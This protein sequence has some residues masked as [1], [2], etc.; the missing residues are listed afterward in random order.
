MT[1]V[2]PL[3]RA[4]AVALAT[5][6]AL[7]AARA[8]RAQPADWPSRPIRLVMPFSAGSG[9]DVITR[10]IARALAERLGTTIVVENKV[11]GTGLVG[12]QEV[13]RAAPDGYTIAYTNIALP[14][15]QELLAKGAFNVAR[16]LTPIGGT[17][18]SINVLVVPPQL[19]ARNVAELVAL[20]KAR[21]GA[22]SYA[23]GGN[24]TP[25]HLAGEVFKRAQGLDVVHVPYKALAAAINDLARGDVHLLFG[26]SGSVV[27]A[28]QGRRLRALAVAGPRRLTALPDVPTMAEAGFPGIDVQSWAG[29][30]AP[31]ATPAPIVARIGQALREVLAEPETA[32]FL[33]TNGSEPFPIG[34]PEFGQLLA[35]ESDRWARFVRE[36]GLTA[37]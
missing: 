13:A 17:S 6:C 37:D 23:S 21:P 4:F 27:P 9:P 20:L 22:Y 7:P 2:D 36:T 26:T 31:R 5:A 32:R 8:V 28:I 30:V 24:G 19:P 34:A 18:R 15:A 33:E 11:G 12:T 14:V 1:A 29:L 35:S 3:R 16:D 10:H 25:A